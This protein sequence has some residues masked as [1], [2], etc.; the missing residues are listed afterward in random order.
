M[1]KEEA[2]R[3]VRAIQRAHVDWIQVHELAF[4]SMRNTSELTC[5]YKQE[6]KEL[7]RHKDAW[8]TLWIKSPREWIDLLTTH[9]DDLELP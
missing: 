8:T 1:D 3:L 2:E 7:F 4:N 6:H 5:A 9:R